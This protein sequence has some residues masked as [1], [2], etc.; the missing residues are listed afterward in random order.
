[1][2]SQYLCGGEFSYSGEITDYLRQQIDVPWWSDAFSIYI[3]AVAAAVV[4]VGMMV[5]AWSASEKAGK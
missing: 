4:A 5:V 2:W 1:M 3:A